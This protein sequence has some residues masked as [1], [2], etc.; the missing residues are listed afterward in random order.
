MLIRNAARS[1]TLALLLVWGS[2]NATAPFL[3]TG[4]GLLGVGTGPLA[5][6]ATGVIT[7]PLGINL[8]GIYYA[9]TEQPFLN[10][11]KG[12]G[13]PMPSGA[14]YPSTGWA[15]GNSTASDTFQ[16][17]YLQLDANGYATSLTASPTPGGGQN[18]NLIYTLVNF[19]IATGAPG[20]TFP[21]P[22]GCYRLQ[23]EGKGTLQLLSPGDVTGVSLSNS[24]ANTYVNTTFTVT[25][26]STGLV[27]AVT[28]ITS[29]TDYPRDISIVQCANT[30]LY[31]AGA[32]FN[33]AFLAM[34]A[35]F[36][37]LRFKD[38]ENT[39][40]EF[41][42]YSATGTVSSGA[43]SLTLTSAWTQPSGTYQ[44]IF[45]D[46]ERK[47]IT[48]TVGATTPTWT[49]GLTNSV[50]TTF[51]SQT[52]SGNFYLDTHPWANR[53]QP[54][55]AFWSLSNGA[56]LE[57]A[58][59]LCNQLS[60]NCY[61]NVP[62]AYSDADI[63][64]M[65]A[66]IMS[67]TGMQSGFVALNSPLTLT[68]EIA[69]ELWNFGGIPFVNQA[70]MAASLGGITWPG[71]PSGG[72]N[73][74][75]GRNYDGMRSAQ[76]AADLQGSLSAGLF[77]RVIPVVNTQAG[78]GSA[79]DMFTVLQATYWTGGTGAPSTYPIKGVVIAPYWG[80]NFTSGDCTTL[81]GVST[82][83]DDFFATMTSQTG[84]SGNG[85]HSYS[86]SVPSGGWLGQAE[87]WIATYAAAMSSFPNQK[88]MSYEG[89]SS[90]FAAAT[91]TGY[92]ALVTNA[93]RD[94]R[95]GTNELAYL[96]YW[97]TTVGAGSANINHLFQDVDNITGSGAFG[98]L[99]N[100]QQTI[101]PLSSAPAKY[102]A[103]AVFA[104]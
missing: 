68:V 26:P 34:L 45:I 29:G 15:T 59:S 89:G 75:W 72:S 30:T 49:G 78:S 99:E 38:W 84:T 92:P 4:T 63:N 76:M 90:F 10:L 21:Y 66:L 83:L 16:N 88:L 96:N 3:S 12:A 40:G 58:V 22:S 35:P 8:Q 48:F 87:G 9:S 70:N 6:G 54:A 93:E 82:P 55:N 43:T 103:A 23:F 62:L 81:T 61:I 79:G 19:Q 69:N 95:M 86:A 7:Q 98:L 24:A 64:A 56:P 18:F 1:I 17:Q 2:A 33:P 25:T 91:C 104:Q 52:Y 74:L 97:K 67:G 46:G 77:A 94:A 36:S 20:V 31:D 39:D 50:G 53:S 44:A 32:I 85:S 13:A 51:G 5:T 57:V 42:P 60:E 41:L 28:A 27:L 102:N 100:I 11:L 73:V 47:N 80:S 101:S 37:S 65:G 71:Q 14:N